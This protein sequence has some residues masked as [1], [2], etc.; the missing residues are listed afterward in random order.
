MRFRTR[1]LPSSLS[2]SRTRFLSSFVAFALRMQLCTAAV[3]TEQTRQ[4]LQ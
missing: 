2:P 4:D 1:T 3:C